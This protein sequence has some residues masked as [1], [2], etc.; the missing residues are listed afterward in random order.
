MIIAEAVLLG[1]AVVIAGM[2]P[3]NLFAAN[4]RYYAPS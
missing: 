2:I 1:M 4:L 3:P